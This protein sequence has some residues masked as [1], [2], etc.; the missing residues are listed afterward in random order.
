MPQSLAQ[1]YTHLIFSTKNRIS[2]LDPSIHES[3]GAYLGGILRALES[4][5]LAIGFARDHV[6]V[7]YCQSRKIALIQTIEELKKSSSKWLKTQGPGFQGFYWQ[8]GY[9]AFSVSASKLEAVRRYVLNQ[10]THHRKTTFEEE[11]RRF[12]E[13]YHVS[14]DERYLWD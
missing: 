7:L 3:L 14:Y 12:L 5:S 6:H 2:V 11:Y 9:G 13:E 1:L 10:P 8:N 4:P